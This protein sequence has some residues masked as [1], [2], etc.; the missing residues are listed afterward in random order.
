MVGVLCLFSILL[1]YQDRSYF[2]GLFTVQKDQ[3]YG[4]E[5]NGKER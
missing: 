3:I 5:D 4:V 2:R 1:L